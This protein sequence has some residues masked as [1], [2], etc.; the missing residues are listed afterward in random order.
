MTMPKE[1]YGWKGR[2]VIKS[3]YEEKLAQQKSGE[4]RKTT[5]TSLQFLLRYFVADYNVAALLQ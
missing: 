1:I 2:I 5:I 3:T 4:K